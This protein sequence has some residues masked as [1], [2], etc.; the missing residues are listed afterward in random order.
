MR[1]SCREL[2]VSHPAATFCVGAVIP[3]ISHVGWVSALR[4][5]ILESERQINKGNPCI[6]QK[7]TLVLP[8][9]VPLH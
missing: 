2:A 8:L 4:R 1:Q 5:P 3:E 7:P 6:E 9:A